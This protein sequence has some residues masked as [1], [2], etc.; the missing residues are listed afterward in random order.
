MLT[1]GPP[2]D[3][4]VPKIVSKLCLDLPVLSP[5]CGALVLHFCTGYLEGMI[6]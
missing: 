5:L 3:C 6:T 1:K 4:D 2:A